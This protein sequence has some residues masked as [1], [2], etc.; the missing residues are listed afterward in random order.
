MLLLLTAI[1]VAILIFWLV[2]LQLNCWQYQGLQSLICFQQLIFQNPP[3]SFSLQQQFLLLDIWIRRF[4]C[5]YVLYEMFTQLLLSTW[6]KQNNSV[7]GCKEGFYK[8]ICI[9]LGVIVAITCSQD[10]NN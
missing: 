7:V 10:D 2:V 3:R 6:I 8:A 1:Q 9:Y 5:G 4:F